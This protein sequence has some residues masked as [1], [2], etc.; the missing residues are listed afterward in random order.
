MTK[1]KVFI[2]YKYWDFDV[3]WLSGY[4]K[5]YAHVRDYVDFI[6]EIM[7]V[8]ESF[9][10]KFE[11]DGEDLSSYSDEVIWDRIK[12]R[13][14]D[15]SVTIVFISPNMKEENKWEISQWIPWEI[16]YSLRETTRNDRTSHSNAIIAVVLPDKNGFYSY[17]DKNNL[18]RILKD[19]IN[20][21]YI[22]VYTWDEFLKDLDKAVLVAEYCKL[23]TPTNL[24]VKTI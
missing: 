6:A 11:N 14:Y 21:G 15:T 10:F 18:F 17:Y 22:P 20:N 5:D 4:S 19:N 24:V 7:E 13:I 8:H 23:K 3:A 2:S 9:I 1:T 16:E 12:D